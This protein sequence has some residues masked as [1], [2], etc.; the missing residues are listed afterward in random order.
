MSLPGADPA[1]PGLPAAVLDARLHDLLL[2]AVI[3]TND[4]SNHAAVTRSLAVASGGKKTSNFLQKPWPCR[5][6]LDDEVITALEGDE[7]GAGNSRR[8][9]ASL[10]QR[11]GRFIAAVQDECRYGDLR[12]QMIDV[13]LVEDPA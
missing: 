8:H 1:N 12:Q 10:F 2:Q 6:V 11:H 13:D 4:H 5:L 7:A 3:D 9:P